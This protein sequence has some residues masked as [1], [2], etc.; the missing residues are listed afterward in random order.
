MVNAPKRIAW[1]W[2]LAGCL[3]AYHC[4]EEALPPVDGAILIGD[5]RPCAA[6]GTST[7]C[8]TLSAEYSE[9]IAQCDETLRWDVSACLLAEFRD[10]AGRAC[11]SSLSCVEFHGRH[12]CVR[13]CPDEGCGGDLVCDSVDGRA[14]CARAVAERDETC[15]PGTACRRSE[16]E[17]RRAY[18]GLEKEAWACKAVCDADDIG[19]PSACAAGELCLRDPLGGAERLSVPATCTSS[20]SCP[21]GFD[22]ALDAGQQRCVRPQAICAVPAPVLDGAIPDDF[23]IEQ[24]CATLGNSRACAEPP[25]DARSAC[26]L[27]PFVSARIDAPICGDDTDCARPDEECL[28]L[29]DEQR[30]AR[31]LRACLLT[32]E[33]EG[34]ADVCG[35]GRSCGRLSLDAYPGLE[36]EVEGNALGQAQTCQPPDDSACRV[37]AGFACIAGAGDTDVCA[38]APLLCVAS[39]T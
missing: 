30:C 36:L 38:R 17:C 5:A 21:E 13:S 9:G 28:P 6:V 4:A 8:A 35:A 29:G 26:A 3:G 27:L 24:S 15:G 16:D 1:A 32:C 23:T 39:G 10:C 19:G 25:G 34:V 31:V 33:E 11:A 37:A 12:R 7:G 14:F 22:C 20:A 18:R 2:G